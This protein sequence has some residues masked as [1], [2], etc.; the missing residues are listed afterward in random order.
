MLAE[1]IKKQENLE[2][3]NLEKTQVV[4]EA[5]SI[6]ILEACCQLTSLNDLDLSKNKSW[7]Q[8]AF[9]VNMLYSCIGKQTNLQ[10]LHL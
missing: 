4:S 9:N 5:Y 10:H 3:L 7:F 1:C 2:Y 6:K 8:S